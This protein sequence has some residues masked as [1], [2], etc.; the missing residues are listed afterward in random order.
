MGADNDAIARRVAAENLEG[1]MMS[2]L[3]QAL[4]SI[5]EVGHKTINFVTCVIKVV[6]A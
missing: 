4:D 6:Y 3:E 5:R 1:I 2:C